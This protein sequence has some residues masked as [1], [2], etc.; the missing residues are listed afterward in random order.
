[1]YIGSRWFRIEVVASYSYICTIVQRQCCTTQPAVL[2]MY[3]VLQCTLCISG[4]LRNDAPV[5]DKDLKSEYIS[6]KI[7][8]LANYTCVGYPKNMNVGMLFKLYER[9]IMLF[10][11]V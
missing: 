4:F 7:R 6:N 1:M 2:Y 8:V 11:I 5:N 9:A 3:N 10:R